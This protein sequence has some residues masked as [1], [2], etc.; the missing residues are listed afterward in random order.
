MVAGESAA[1]SPDGTK[2]AYD[3]EGWLYT[4]DIGTHTVTGLQVEGRRPA[5]SPD[6]GKIAFSRESDIYIMDFD[7]GEITNATNGIGG[8]GFAMWTP[9][10]DGILFISSRDGLGEFMPSRELYSNGLFKLDL[11]TGRVR[12]LSEYDD[13]FITWYAIVN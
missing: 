12:R 1:W 9:N 13:I 3:L 7:L 10:G 2:I 11:M 4:V 5:W 8:N 6:G